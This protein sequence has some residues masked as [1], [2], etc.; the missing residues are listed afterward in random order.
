MFAADVTWE[1]SVP[2]ER[3]AALTAALVEL[4]R[5]EIEVVV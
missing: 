2:E 5:G 4:S 1:I 3:A